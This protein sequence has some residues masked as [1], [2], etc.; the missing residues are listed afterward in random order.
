V[1]RCPFAATLLTAAPISSPLVKSIIAATAEYHAASQPL[2]SCRWPSAP[3]RLSTVPA[4]SAPSGRRL[5]GGRC[6]AGLQQQPRYGRAARPPQP[7]TRRIAACAPGQCGS[8][9]Q[10]RPPA[11]RRCLDGQLRCA[12]LLLL[13]PLLPP[14][15]HCRPA[16]PPCCPATSAGSAFTCKGQS[17][18]AAATAAAAGALSR[19]FKY[20]NHVAIV[21]GASLPRDVSPRSSS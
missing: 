1:L 16:A 12:R 3:H 20:I 15:P 7:A 10:A 17:G 13:A 9:Q 14:D 21:P 2:R 4:T 6:C 8:P 18:R 11:W 19:E 5:G